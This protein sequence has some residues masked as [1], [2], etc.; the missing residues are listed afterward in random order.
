[1]ADFAVFIVD[2]DDDDFYIIREAFVRAGNTCDLHHVN[3]GKLLLEELS[4]IRQ[5]S[6]KYPD[7][8]LLDINMPK[9]DGVRA[10]ELIKRDGAYR[11]IPVIIYSTSSSPE[12]TDKCM[13]LG[14]KAVVL[15][16]WNFEKVIAFAH[17]INRFLHDPEA[18][19]DFGNNGED[20]TD[21]IKTVLF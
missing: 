5:T 21:E 1:M 13:D 10:L 19:R 15:K 18:L 17:K 14:A 16:G 11:Q 20:E 6:R 2:D 3:N 9:M 8:I 4:Y 12:Q 7:L